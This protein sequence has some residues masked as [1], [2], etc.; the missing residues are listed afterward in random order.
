MDVF[1]HNQP[2]LWSCPADPLSIGHIVDRSSRCTALCGTASQC[3]STP[4]T[5]YWPTRAAPATGKAAAN[6]GKRLA[7]A[8]HGAV[9]GASQRAGEVYLTPSGLHVE[10]VRCVMLQC[11]D[12]G[13]VHVLVEELRKDRERCRRSVSATHLCMF[14]HAIHE[15]S[16]TWVCFPEILRSRF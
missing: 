1:L 4:Q 14:Y 7:V 2:S 8:R 6:R 11:D 12:L 16:A 15:F 9:F 3:Q 13:K 10:H 5:L